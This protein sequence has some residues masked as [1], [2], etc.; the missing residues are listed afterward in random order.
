MGDQ[1]L[2]SWAVLSKAVEL[3]KLGEDFVLATV[4]WRQ[5]PSSGQHGSRAIVMASGE[6][7][8]WIGGA[9]AEPVLL[10]EA[11]RALADRKPRL[12]ML[13]ESEQLGAIAEGITQIAISCQSDGALQIYLEP[14]Q[15]TP[16][17]VVVGRS[18]MAH[19][20]HDLAVSLDWRAEII[21]GTDFSSADFD[22]RS[23]VV[24]ATQGHGDE[25][26]TEVA[27]AG[28]PAYVGLVASR[29]RGE[30][31]LGYL[32]DKGI[33]QDLLENVRVPAG[34]DL[35]HTNH[36]EMAVAVLAQLVQLRAAGK[37][38]TSSA[39]T[40]K[41]VV[42]PIC[43]MTVN[44]DRTSQAVEF[45]GVTYFFCCSGCRDTFAKDPIA[46]VSKEARC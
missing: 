15:I 22:A 14:V 34:L 31:V 3:A 13:G 17:L 32:A 41:L 26:L 43:G 12:L 45:N 20:L 2:D 40:T 38:V 18:P 46:H 33:A 19:T 28:K 27:I 5:G 35:G 37:I 11:Q 8:G 25:E 10:R 16:H 29:R 39:M 36:R 44:A 6:I 30:A 7:H 1:T 24:I 9:C 21:D 42:D 23:L 4:V